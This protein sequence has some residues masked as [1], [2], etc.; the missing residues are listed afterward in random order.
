MKHIAERTLSK[1]FDGELG[2]AETVTVAEHLEEC[3]RC[4]ESYEQLTALSAQLDNLPT[5]EPG[6]YFASR[7][8]R[9]AKEEHR[10]PFPTR[11]LVPVATA[12]RLISLLI[13]GYQGQSVYTALSDEV[14]EYENGSAEYFDVSPMQDYPEGSF[15]DVYADIM[16]EEAND[17][18]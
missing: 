5:A 18:G 17:E 9:T 10:K 14:P 6:P 13:G 16:S 7:M 11:F 4:R 1:Y 3:P 8:K 15:G 12:A 2:E